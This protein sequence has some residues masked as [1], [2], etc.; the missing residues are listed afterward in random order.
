MGSPDSD[1]RSITLRLLRD[2][3]VTTG[4]G[5]RRLMLDRIAAVRRAVLAAVACWVGVAGLGLS[6]LGLSGLGLSAGAAASASTV[7]SPSSASPSASAVL[8]GSELASRG[9]V[10]NYPSRS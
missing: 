6:G 7:P 9:T 1:V 4:Q 2:R 10:V 5:A 3:R 8:G